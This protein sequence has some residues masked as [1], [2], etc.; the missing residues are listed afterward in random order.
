MSEAYQ[1]VVVG[2]G[3][4]GLSAAAR[5]AKRGMK[6][7][8]LEATPAI[9]KTIQDYQVGKHVMAEPGVLPLRAE[10]RFDVGTREQVLGAWERGAQE[11]DLNIRFNAEVQSIRGQKGDF[12]IKLAN[13]ESLSAEHVVLTIGVQGNPRQ[14]GVAGEELP[15]LHATLPG[16]AA[17]RGETVVV[18]GAGD[19]AIENA[20]AL[21]D[22]NQVYIVNRRDEF[23]RAKEGNLA[24]IL[25]AID[26]GKLQCCYSSSPASIEA[27]PEAV[28]PYLF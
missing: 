17:H 22:R 3:P 20:V 27:T 12:Q 15:R 28:K 1:V 21:A 4:A 11:L 18:V 25:D 2:A 16:P 24:L 13:G 6:Y 8:L 19:A 5:A 14:L 23:A 10:L 26:S 9:A 7:V